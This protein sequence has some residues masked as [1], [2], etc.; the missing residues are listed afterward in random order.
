MLL[1]PALGALGA[2]VA[3]VLS[4]LIASGAQARNSQPTATMQPPT[5][6]PA[7]GW[8]ILSTGPTDDRQFTP[9]TWAASDPGGVQPDAFDLFKGLRKLTRQGILIWASNSGRGSPTRVFTPAHW[10]LQLSTFRVDRGW[11]GQPAANVQQRLRW[12]SVDGWHLD[13]RVYFGTQHPSAALR[14]KAQAELNRL[15]LPRR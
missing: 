13:I 7:L 9:E 1:P 8:W 12:A 15:Q 2:L 5:F 3:L 11:E 4:A 14:A 10:P 6:K